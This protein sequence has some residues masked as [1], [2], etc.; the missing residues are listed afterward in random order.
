MIQLY[1]FDNT[2]AEGEK[3][4]VMPPDVPQMKNRLIAN[5]INNFRK[6]VNEIV[7]A[8]NPK[9]GGIPYGTFRLKAKGTDEGVVN[10]NFDLEVGDIVEGYG[11]GDMIYK[12]GDIS[13]PINYKN[14][15]ENTQTVRKPP[16]VVSYFLKDSDHLKD[17]VV[18][19]ECNFQLGNIIGI[20][21]CGILITE[22]VEVTVLSA[23][24]S[25]SRVIDGV[26]SSG[27]QILNAGYYKIK[28]IGLT[29]NFV[30]CQ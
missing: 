28:R 22:T 23:G 9:F 1:E 24:V 29:S 3:E 14:Y 25:L 26:K 10:T 7:T 19:T 13:L 5:E 15:V 11:T 18:I 21:E 30:I 8:L 2:N 17:N 12:G 16:S 20:F 27:D 4:A 6:K